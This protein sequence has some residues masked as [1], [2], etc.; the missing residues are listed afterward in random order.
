[1]PVDVAVIALN[2]PDFQSLL[3]EGQDFVIGDQR[4]SKTETFIVNH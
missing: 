4:G 3:Q 2:N 1:M